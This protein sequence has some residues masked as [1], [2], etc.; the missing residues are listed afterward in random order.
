MQEKNSE[1]SGL[2]GDAESSSRN[3]FMRRMTMST[4]LEELTQAVIGGNAD[5][6]KDITGKALA[7]KID[8]L[9]VLQKALVPAMAEVG[10]RMQAEEYYIPDVIVSARAMR[11]SSDILKPLIAG[12]PNNKPLGTVVI[13]TVFGDMHDIGKNLVVMMLEGASFQIHD[14]G[15]NVPAAQFV[16]KVNEVKPTIVA[17]S[18]MLT[19]TMMVMREIIEALKKAGVRDSVKVIIGGA[20]VTQR[21]ADDIG[22]DGYAGDAA[23][24]ADLAKR[25]CR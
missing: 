16:A 24:A 2:Q 19:T 14:L 12:N 11:A 23:S 21:F 1:Q 18:A 17:L 15:I 20:P 13:G 9:E 8:P 10:R 25:L 6:A 5:A 22:A 4:V 3:Q 7:E